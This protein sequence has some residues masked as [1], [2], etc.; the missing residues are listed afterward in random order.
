[1]TI[2]NVILIVEIQEV[3]MFTPPISHL[4]RELLSFRLEMT[5]RFQVDQKI[6]ESL[7]EFR[8]ESNR[9]LGNLEENVTKILAILERRFPPDA[10]SD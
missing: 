5:E 6:L 3:V 8:T 4:Q 10:E 1:M 9:R 7:S 2:K